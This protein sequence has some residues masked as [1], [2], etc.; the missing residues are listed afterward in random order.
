MHQLTQ[1]YPN[2]NSSIFHSQNS[3]FKLSLHKVP[4]ALS[5][6]FTERGHIDRNFQEYERRER[7]RF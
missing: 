3:S 1:T 6:I 7:R 2:I 5:S 4:S